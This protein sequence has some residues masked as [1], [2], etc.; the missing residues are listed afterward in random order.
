MKKLVSIVLVVT[1]LLSMS[2]T[3]FSE[4]GKDGLEAES[5]EMTEVSLK[6]AE[7]LK[8]DGSHTV[9]DNGDAKQNISDIEPLKLGSI[10]TEPVCI[11]KSIQTDSSSLKD[12]FSDF[13]INVNDYRKRES[14]SEYQVGEYTKYVNVED[15]SYFC[16]DDNNQIIR[17][18]GL[19]V[20]NN[21]IPSTYVMSNYDEA[22]SNVASIHANEFRRSTP[23]TR[24]FNESEAEQMVRNLCHL[25]RDY[26]LTTSEEFDK[27]LWN[28]VWMK[29]YDNGLLNP[30][31]SVK[32]T[33]NKNTMELEYLR[34]FDIPVKASELVLSEENAV[35]IAS[36]LIQKLGTGEITG[37]S[38][39]YFCPN[40]FW[41]EGEY[42]QADFVRLC[43][44]IDVDD[45]YIIYIDAETGRNLGGTEVQSER[46][47]SFSQTDTYYESGTKTRILVSN[48][49]ARL[50]WTPVESLS[51][52]NGTNLRTKVLDYVQNKSD[53]YA[54]YFRGHGRSP[55]SRAGAR[56]SIKVGNDYSGILYPSEV[57][58]NWHF[59]YL[60][61][62]DTAD[63]D[64]WAKA[65]KITN[66]SVNRGF[67]GYK[68]SA[69]IHYTALFADNF[70]NL[71]PSKTVRAAAIAAANEVP[72]LNDGTKTT[73]IR[74]YGDYSY[75]GKP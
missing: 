74:F 60:D 14:Y 54:F 15:D 71:L 33:V 22:T 68:G 23:L 61:A 18:D 49:F 66:S 31:E 56:L 1:L 37:T 70:W 13:G 35:E 3:V 52:D 25:G 65:F 8:N 39:A 46:A 50:G 72:N 19:N 62:C 53:A 5:I 10:D 27:Q 20:I 9:G 59:V 7:Q 40:Y 55:S 2:I 47:G 58:G 34:R 73:P 11:A 48:A 21:R 75:R 69:Y 64:T 38:L 63:D 41:D 51:T 57:K 42:E 30:M 16:L 4:D 45:H 32:A 24:R 12:E 28:F 17:F 67:L 44:R 43:Y 36:D 29:Q 6:D 26:V